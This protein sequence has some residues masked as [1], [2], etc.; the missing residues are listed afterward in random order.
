MDARNAIGNSALLMTCSDVHRAS[1]SARLRLAELLVAEGAEPCGANAAGLTAAHLASKLGSAPL[2]RFVLRAV[3]AGAADAADADERV[4]AAADAPASDG[5]YG[6][7]HL[8]A[9][10]GHFACAQVL[11]ACGADP[12]AVATHKGAATPLDLA[13]RAAADDESAGESESE[14]T[15]EGEGDRYERAERAALRAA[16]AERQAIVALLRASGA[17]ESEPPTESPSDAE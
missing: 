17:Q 16:R 3:A 15:S 1:A 9:K 14:G 10:K 4:R 12:S 8:A 6:P 11:L 7:L 2:L 13:L 5:G